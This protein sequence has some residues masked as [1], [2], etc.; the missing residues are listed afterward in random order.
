MNTMR[1]ERFFKELNS[2]YMCA[3]YESIADC[4][5]LPCAVYVGD[6]VLVFSNR[7]QLLASLRE[8]CAGNRE[9]GCVA[10]SNTVINQGDLKGQSYSAW[11]HWSHWD[12]HGAL[13]FMTKARYFCTDADNGVPQIK[14]VQFTEVP[15]SYR[16]SGPQDQDRLRCAGG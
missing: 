10:V 1:I 9:L 5:S 6:D 4:H 12:K 11:V 2:A 7:P 3:D 15:R 13:L 16:T 14:M 8:Q